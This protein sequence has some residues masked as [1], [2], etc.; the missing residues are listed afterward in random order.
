MNNGERKVPLEPAFA[1]KESTMATTESQTESAALRK[2]AIELLRQ[3]DA[4]DAN[5]SNGGSASGNGHGRSQAQSGSAS[6]SQ[7]SERPDPGQGVSTS[8]PGR[9]KQGG[10]F[11]DMDEDFPIAVSELIVSIKGISFPAGKKEMERI[12]RKRGARDGVIH[13]I[14]RFRDKKFRTMPEVFHEFSLV[15][16]AEAE[17]I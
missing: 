4:V 3:A 2:K 16:R 1:G 8:H 12:A 14:N 10:V 6:P 13:A 11:Q 5:G 7:G 15:K 17:E 9:E